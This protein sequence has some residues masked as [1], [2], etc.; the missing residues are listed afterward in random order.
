MPRLDRA[1]G[2]VRAAT[3]LATPRPAWAAGIRGAIATVLPLVASSALHLGGATWMSLGGFNG[4]LADRGGAYRTRAA[5]M[6]AVTVAG[7]AAV[8]LGTLA[9]GRPAFALP[10]VFAVALFAGLTRA[11]GSAGVSLGGA[12]LSTLVIALAEP[13]GPALDALTNAGFA[14]VGGSAAMAIALLVWPLRPFRPARI[15]VARGYEAL[16]D[17]A[18]D[19]ARYGHARSGGP[20]MPVP[21]GSAQVRA[22]LEAAR[23]VLA[24]MRRGRPG[25]TGREQHLIVL[26]E[27]V[28]QIFGHLVALGETLD[29]IAPD[30][31]IAAADVALSAAIEE[32]AVT[33]RKLAGA[34]LVERAPA[35][36]EVTWS[37]NAVRRAAAGAQSGNAGPHYEAAAA[38]LDRAAQYASVAAVTA[39]ALDGGAAPPSTPRAMAAEVADEPAGP[40]ALLTAV[41]APDS[42]ILRHALRLAVVT[43]VAVALAEVFHLRR[44]Y[45]LTITVV[46]MLQPYTSATT[47][48]ALQRVLGTVLGGV[49]TALLGAAFHDPRAILV[50]SFL[51]AAAC[52]ALLP[53]NYAAYSVFL[54]PTFVLL[55]ESGAGDWHLVTARVTNTLL[56]GALALAGA[57][58]LWPSP[59]SRRL[60]GY[61]A[62]AAERS[63]E[64]LSCVVKLFDDRSGEAGKQIRGARRHLGLATVNAEESFERMV[65]EYDGPP[66]DL[67]PVMTFLTYTRRFAASTAALALARHVRGSDASRA[68]APFAARADAVLEDLARAAGERRRPA[69]LPILVV[70]AELDQNESPLLR[71]RVDRVSRQIRMLHDALDRWAAEA[72]EPGP[73]SR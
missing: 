13:G 14:I 41:L 40:I 68:L 21:A 45:W 22:A 1:L 32:L 63:R 56:G 72:D 11:W 49:I 65:A 8:L 50:L 16:A 54:T 66:G 59:E 62:A 64:Y 42:L 38:I 26:G 51:F 57:R 30:E 47:N 18:D 43:T 4:A 23:T 73:A 46:V 15:A 39:D 58:L 9:S 10:L 17:Y 52:I 25:T 70:E 19:V 55:A 24:E 36:V 2:T 20:Q 67:S 3:A 69:P 29:S 12:A 37:G 53:V 27:G 60:P 28:D 48:R 44:G 6:A 35:P 5:T 31:R 71:A 61:L 7:A 34:V 33:A